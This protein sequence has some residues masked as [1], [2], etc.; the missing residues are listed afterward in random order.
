MPVRLLLFAAI[1]AVSAS[2]YATASTKTLGGWTFFDV[3]VSSDKE[4]MTACN[5][6]C[7]KDAVCVAVS[8]NINPPRG[9]G[10]ILGGDAVCRCMKPAGA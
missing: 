5:D 7:G 3:R 6:L 4:W 2:A 9:C 10:D 8:S 1:V